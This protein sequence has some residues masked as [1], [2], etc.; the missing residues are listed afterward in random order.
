MNFDDAP[1]T[2]NIEKKARISIPTKVDAEE[3][4]K[5][6]HIP[7]TIASFM[8]RRIKEMGDEGM[9]SEFDK[10]QIRGVLQ[11]FIDNLGVCERIRKTPIPFSHSTF[12]K[13]FILIICHET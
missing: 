1:K 13:L 6:K 2:D 9:L 4:E 8:H 12:I 3:L 5:A 11:G 10:N 7:N